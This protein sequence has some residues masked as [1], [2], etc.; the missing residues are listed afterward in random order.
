MCGWCI[1]NLTRFI[2]NSWLSMYPQDSIKLWLLEY[3]NSIQQ[4][5]WFEPLATATQTNGSDTERWLRNVRDRNAAVTDGV[6]HCIAH[7]LPNI[8]PP[9][10]YTSYLI[11][12]AMSLWF[13]VRQNSLSLYTCTNSCVPSTTFSHSLHFSIDNND[14]LVPGSNFQVYSVIPK[15]NLIYSNEYKI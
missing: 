2:T 9:Q 11:T 7:V 8:L 1:R 13:G 6:P 3:G 15:W 14:V 12:R 10:S 5:G 4:F